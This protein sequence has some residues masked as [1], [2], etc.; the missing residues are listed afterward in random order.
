MSADERPARVSDP[1][2]GPAAS[3]FGRREEGAT[4]D[5]SAPVAWVSGELRTLLSQRLLSGGLAAA[6]A[7]VAGAAMVA[8]LA[9]PSLGHGLILGWLGAVVVLA[10]LRWLR[11][12]LVGRRGLGPTAVV[13]AVRVTAGLIALAW[14]VGAAVALPS[15]APASEALLL[16]VIVALLAGASHTLVADRLAAVVYG[17][18]LLV[19][20]TVAALLRGIETRHLAV[21][22]VLGLFAVV[23][24][25]FHGEAHAVLVA[26]ITAAKELEFSER[27]A[28]RERRFLSALLGSAPVAIAAVGGTG[29]VTAVNP[30]FERLFGYGAA[31]CLDRNINDL[32][33]PDAERAAAQAWDVDARDG[34]GIVRDAERRRKDGRRIPVRLS[35]AAVQGDPDGTLFV[36]YEDITALKRSEAALRE[37]EAQYHALVE[38]ATD[39]VFQVDLEGRWTFLNQASRE[40]YGAD[41]ESLLG[42]PMFERMSPDHV[43]S[44]RAAFERV[45]AGE[46]VVDHETVHQGVQGEQRHLSFSCLPARDEQGR[47]TGAIGI[48]RDVGAAVRVRQALEAARDVAERTAV[49]KAAFLANMS[50][51]IRTPL[52]GILGMVEILLDTDLTAEQR[53]AADLVKTSGEALLDILNDVLDYSKI[54]AGHVQLEETAFDLPGVV[55]SVAGLLGARAFEKGIEMVADIAPD[56][57]PLV[58]GDPGRLR[59]VLINLVGNAVKFTPEGEVVLRAAPVRVDGDRVEVEFVVRDTGIGIPADKLQTVFEEFAQADVSTTRR[60]GGTGLGLSISRRLVRLMGGELS[61]DSGEGRG[62]SFR[63]VLGLGIERGGLA[64]AQG[65]SSEVLAN[66]RVLVVD[67]N[68]TNRQVIRRFLEDARA[69]VTE[70]ADARVALAALRTAAEAGGAYALAVIDGYMPETDG[71]Q[72]AAEVRA[73]ARL[74]GTPLMMLTSAGRRGD[75]ARCQELGITGY[76]TKPVPRMELLEAAITVLAG[77]VEGARLVTRHTIVESRRR[78]RILVAE[79]NAVNQQ[80]ARALLTKRGHD[81]DVVAN[82]REALVALRERPY[83]VVLMDVQMPELDGLEATREARTIPGCEQLPI[84]A[85]TAHAFADD[86]DR[87]LAAGMSAVVTKPFKPHQL[88]AAVEGWA[89]PSKAPAVA[90]SAEPE[91]VAADAAGSPG[92]A[93]APVDLVAL[94]GALREGGV[95]DMLGTLVASFLQDAPGRVASIEDAVRAGDAERIRQAAHA[96]KSSAAQLGARALAEGLQALE[97]AGR[98][99]D[100]AAAQSLAGG[101][102]REHEVVCAFLA[103]ATAGGG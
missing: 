27:R 88:F 83:D 100:L 90:P 45:L 82:G 20:P 25:R 79:D 36:L 78:L 44:D 42:R 73:D 102:R 29:R 33:V 87:F 93:A 62:T 59:Q 9:W 7:N 28:V 64:P 65:L 14:G 46:R 22:T 41:P 84:V 57:P 24:W 53:R 61:V 95:E 47:L 74:S 55:H 31:E 2:P 70:A 12:G 60:F 15:L 68:A 81:V 66:A 51:E 71:F 86:R 39:L 19:P 97:L 91:G 80:V 101:V 63:F 34:R 94:R 49:A 96:Y 98:G 3:F 16:A 67:D 56:L 99:G 40:I 77:G 35:A 52:N 8:A 69:V 85:L 32:I 76:L 92:G 43:E 1:P 6:V 21:V 18:A 23:M 10:A 103:A 38:S 11:P 75:A 4:A 5:E 13:Y 26:Q 48:A 58:R 50:H 37:A 17:A 30:A 72:L 89:G 54:E